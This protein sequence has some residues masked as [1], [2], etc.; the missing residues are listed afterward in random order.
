MAADRIPL[1]IP[2]KTDAHKTFALQMCALLTYMYVA[3][4]LYRSLKRLLSCLLFLI[5]FQV[6]LNLWCNR[7]SLLHPERQNSNIQFTIF[8]VICL[9]SMWLAGACLAWNSPF[10][11]L[12]HAGWS[13]GPPSTSSMQLVYVGVEGEEPVLMPLTCTSPKGTLP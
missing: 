11:W 9:S 6:M 12:A 2:W 7:Q 8:T 10:T 3:S 4:I 13:S 5:L 1:C